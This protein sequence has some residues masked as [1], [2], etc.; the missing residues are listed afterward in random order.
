[1]VFLSISGGWSS[2]FLGKK[3]T[4]F[5][6]SWFDAVIGFIYLKLNEFYAYLLLL[7]PWY[8]FTPLFPTLFIM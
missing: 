5:T 3:L 8:W 2:T 7:I 6:P 4:N 1:M